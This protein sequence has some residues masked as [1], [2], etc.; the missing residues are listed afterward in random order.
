MGL[1]EA[2]S[3]I[4]ESGFTSGC[5]LRTGVLGLWLV[6]FFALRLFSAVLVKFESIS[7]ILASA[8]LCEAV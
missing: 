4:G 3:F 6:L 7:V 2:S 5:L 8:F 1:R